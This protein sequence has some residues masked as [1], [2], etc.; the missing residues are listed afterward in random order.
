MSQIAG[1]SPGLRKGS[2]KTMGTLAIYGSSGFAREILPIV[3]RSS[4]GA[5]V[6]VDD[7]VAVQG[8]S[9]NG[10]PC[11]SFEELCARNTAQT[12]ISI[13]ISA[14]DIRQRLTEKCSAAGF[15]FFDVTTQSH[16][17]FDEVE[18]GPGAILCDHTQITSNIRIGAH[19]HCNIYSYVAHDCVIGDFVTFAPRVNCNGNIVIEDGAYIG[20]GATLRQGTP[21]NPLRIGTGSTVGMGAVVTK[22]VPPGATVVGNPAKI[23]DP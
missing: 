19:F 20:T 12:K 17:R 5:I 23:L 4:E 18:I 16:L 7:E 15:G 10:I 8:T 22:D 1:K 14:P 6:F 2:L 11:I 3:R 21:D 9:V 13:A